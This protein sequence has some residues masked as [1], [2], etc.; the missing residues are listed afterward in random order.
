MTSF[1][2]F[3]ILGGVSREHLA[4][5]EALQLQ[6]MNNTG[7]KIVQMPK[8]GKRKIM[9]LILIAALISLLAITVYAV[10]TRILN[11][12]AVETE[13]L[14]SSGYQDMPEVGE[15]SKTWG[16]EDINMALEFSMQN[17][18]AAG[19][20]L[21]C[22]G[23][24]YLPENMPQAGETPDKVALE[25]EFWLEKWNGTAYEEVPTKSGQSWITGEKSI[26]KDGWDYSGSWPVSWTD[27]YGN[28]GE[29]NYRVGMMLDI[30][31]PDG[32]VVQKG[33]FAKF[34]QYN[35]DVQPLVEEFKQAY[36][37][38]K[39]KDCFHV[40]ETKWMHT[41]YNNHKEIEY[42][43]LQI[44]DWKYGSNALNSLTY[45]LEA[46]N[47]RELYDHHGVMTRDGVEYSISWTS[48]DVS[49]PLSKWMNIDWAD[50]LNYT[51]WQTILDI[52]TYDISDAAKFNNTVCFYH[53]GEWN[54]PVQD[55]QTGEE[56][57]DANGF[58]IWE[59]VPIFVEYK[60]LYS[61]DGEIQELQ[62][63][64]VPEL[65]Y[66]PEERELV[67][68]IQI[69]DDTP[70]EID[71]VIRSIDVENPPVFSYKQ[72]LARLAD[73]TFN[74]YTDGYK[75]TYKE[76]VEAG[77][78]KL[79]LEQK[80]DGFVNTTPQEVTKDNVVQ[81]A[82]KEVKESYNTTVMY[83]DNDTQMWKVEFLVSSDTSPYHAVYISTTGV[84]QLVVERYEIK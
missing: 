57:K 62:Y 65:P 82:A 66:E 56:K 20:T 63:A 18:N 50:D 47:G 78:V 33:C 15:G 31:M 73:G 22:K 10:A 29:G 67:A 14:E 43:Y 61:D 8:N 54:Y 16:F 76:L 1:E 28:L 37:R 25:S 9:R 75:G 84:T 45:I 26:I 32:Q 52:A 44:E 39:D 55:S 53:E 70:E 21:I 2:L 23:T 42:T 17:A 71:A 83:F 74:E 5:A 12:T 40:I 77:Y 49:S 13:R 59:S 48:E 19:G 46:E 79:H 60:V 58:T 81:L 68:R 38:L 27:A 36:S 30:T 11:W 34:R 6:E 24:S 80:T 72:D 69:L 41:K 64:M 51:M 35:P 3:S 4:G 7:A